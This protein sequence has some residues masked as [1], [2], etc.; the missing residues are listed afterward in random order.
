[1]LAFQIL[2]LIIAFNPE[3]T[4]NNVSSS[5]EDNMRQR[6]KATCKNKCTKSNSNNNL[7]RFPAQPSHFTSTTE[8]KIICAFDQDIQVFEG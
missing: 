3:Q 5:M 2:L 1:M 8:N 7:L 6:K 4:E